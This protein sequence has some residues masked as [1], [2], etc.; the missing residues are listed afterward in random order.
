MRDILSIKLFRARHSSFASD[1]NNVK[2]V[3]S[4]C[5]NCRMKRYGPKLL[6]WWIAGGQINHTPCVLQQLCCFKSAV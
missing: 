2:N 5:L 1:F 6:H 3:R 4:L